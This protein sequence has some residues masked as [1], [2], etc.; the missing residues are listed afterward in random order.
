MEKEV[1]VVF[2]FNTICEES[3]VDIIAVCETEEAAK[4]AMMTDVEYMTSEFCGEDIDDYDIKNFDT[5]CHI[6]P[7]YDAGEYVVQILRRKLC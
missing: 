6:T 5:R 7:K 2:S 3:D 4:K 1:F